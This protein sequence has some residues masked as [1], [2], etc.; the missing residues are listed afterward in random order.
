MFKFFLYLHWLSL[1]FS[2]AKQKNA[3]IVICFKTR[4]IY[5]FICLL[6]FFSFSIHERSLEL[7]A[8]VSGPTRKLCEE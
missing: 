1:V 7:F 6:V 3:Q 8:V 5:S 2:I 4:D